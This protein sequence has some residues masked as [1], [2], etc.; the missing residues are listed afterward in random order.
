MWRFWPLKA[1]SHCTLTTAVT[2]PSRTLMSPSA[3]YSCQTTTTI[4]DHLL[5]F[6]IIRKDSITKLTLAKVAEYECSC[7]RQ[8]LNLARTQARFKI[9]AHRYKKIFLRSRKWNKD[10]SLGYVFSH[11]LLRKWFHVS[12]NGP[13]YTLGVAQTNQLVDFSALP[14]RFK[15]TSR[16]SYRWAQ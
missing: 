11:S 2:E 7:I 16:W 10:W 4:S 15:L 14:W 6:G 9:V 12:F 3:W 13:Y 8:G 1:S 5:A